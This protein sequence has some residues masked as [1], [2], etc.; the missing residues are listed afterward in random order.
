M[1]TKLNLQEIETLITALEKWEQR[2]MADG[3]VDIM[4]TSL[5]EGHLSPEQTQIAQQKSKERERKS[6][7]AHRERKERATL[8][9]AK[10]IEMKYAMRLQR[11]LGLGANQT[12]GE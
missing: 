11:D 3:L 6:E 8:I 4:M 12:Q 7:E 9:K 1:E 10:L 2:D 5:V